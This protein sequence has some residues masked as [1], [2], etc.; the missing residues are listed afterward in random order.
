MLQATGDSHTVGPANF[1]RQAADARQ[2][3]EYLSEVLLG[4]RLR[5]ANCHDH[6]LDRWT[7]NDYHGLA[8]M[9][10]GVQRGQVVALRPGGEVIHPATG[11]PAV[12][13]VPGG[14]PLPDHRAAL[15]VLA[16]WVTAPDNPSFAPFWVNRLWPALLGR[17]LVEPVD[18]LRATNP[19][20]HPRL[21]R[22]LA[23]DF[24][25]AGYDLRH[26]LALIVRSAVYQRQ[27]YLDMPPRGDEAFFPRAMVRPLPVPVVL[28]MLQDVLEID[29]GDALPGSDLPAAG[30]PGEAEARPAP[31]RRRVIEQAWMPQAMAQLGPLVGCRQPRT[32]LAPLD[33]PVGLE[34]L[35][36]QLHWLNG[37]LL[38]EPLARRQHALA[39]LASAASDVDAFVREAY[40]R[41]LSRLPS[42][43]EQALWRRE[44]SADDRQERIDDFLWSLLSCPE[45]LT[46]H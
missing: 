16:E 36:V 26:T 23:D 38:N 22:R 17:G 4:I 8:A 34:D 35:A 25:A 3:A 7:Q 42:P 13:R 43:K 6:P 10:A 24:A 18:D 40:L 20:S 39:R 14:P 44:L 37:R 21:L 46:N 29:L 12:P 30:P 2:A 28:D 15:D 5:C 27:S 32:C 11:L 1:H 41:T 9:L 33:Q 19:A 45:F 31:P